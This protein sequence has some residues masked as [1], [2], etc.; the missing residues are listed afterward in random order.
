[1][2]QFLVCKHLGRLQPLDDIGAQYLSKIKPNE[3]F[4]VEI[5]RARNPRQHRLYWALCNLV[6]DNSEAY[7]TADQVSFV[8]KIATGHTMPTVGHDG[9]TY[10][11][12]RS[13]AFHAM[14]Q[15]EFRKFLDRCIDVVVTKLLPKVTSEELRAE[16]ESICGVQSSAA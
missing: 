12:P 6:A 2:T 7:D 15:E 16:L 14:P 11:Q 4:L 10:W 1:M 5:K 9:R 8:F 3:T 13:I